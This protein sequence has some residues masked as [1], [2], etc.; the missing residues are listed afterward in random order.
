MKL[1]KEGNILIN[2][3][4]V[5]KLGSLHCVAF[6]AIVTEGVNKAPYLNP[7]GVAINARVFKA[8]GISTHHQLKCRREL[9]ELGLI[10]SEL[11][12]LPARL[13]FTIDK[14]CESNLEKLLLS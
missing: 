11:K 12:G 7:H 4:L 13:Y 2:K 3:E 6:Y 9:E 1:S 10:K 5:H 14:E 8:F